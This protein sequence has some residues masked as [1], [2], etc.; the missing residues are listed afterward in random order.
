MLVLLRT[1]NSHLLDDP[2]T[3]HGDYWS[4]LVKLMQF[5][6]DRFARVLHSG[7]FIAKKVDLAN[8]PRS[9]NISGLNDD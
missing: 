1:L 4:Q 5:F 3:E 6:R 2:Q 9:L 8:N 7:I